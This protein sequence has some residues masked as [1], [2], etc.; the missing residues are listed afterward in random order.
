MTT[1]TNVSSRFGHRD[2]VM[3]GDRNPRSL[4]LSFVRQDDG[5]VSMIFQANPVLQGYRDTLHGGIIASLMDAA[6]AHC[7][8]HQGIQAITGDL[9][10]R[11]LHPFPSDASLLV[12]AW[13]QLIRIPL[14]L[15]RSEI[16]LGAKRMTWAESK[17]MQYRGNSDVC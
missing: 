17:F 8:F 4:H 1:D 10:V 11:Y 6:M 2:C 9:H 7:L 16:V 13:I 12:R 3:C 14:I 5:S 15:L